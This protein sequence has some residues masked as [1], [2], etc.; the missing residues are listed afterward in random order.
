M[1]DVA[2]LA[3]QLAAEM[4]GECQAEDD[5]TYTLLITSDE[6]PLVAVT[7]YSDVISEGPAK[8]AEMLMLRALAGTLEEGIETF[9]IEDAC[10]TWFARCYLEEETEDE[11]SSIDV[12]VEAGLPLVGLDV[13][14]LQQALVEVV[15]L[16]NCADDYVLEEEDDEDDEG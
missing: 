6:E 12:I 11:E 10:S 14:V 4:G 16:V 1:A 2:E 5:G 9:L 7:L 15:D 3:Q 8:G 13:K